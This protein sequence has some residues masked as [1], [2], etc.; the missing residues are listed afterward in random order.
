MYEY[1]EITTYFFYSLWWFTDI[2]WKMV[3]ADFH[4]AHILL[5]ITTFQIKNIH[6]SMYTY[7]TFEVEPE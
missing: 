1:D 6:V 4:V 7:K 2:A 5:Q 3:L